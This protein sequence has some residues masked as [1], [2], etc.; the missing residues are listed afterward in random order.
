MRIQDLENVTFVFKDFKHFPGKQPEQ[1]KTLGGCP[2]EGVTVLRELGG[3][4]E[5]GDPE[6]LFC[7]FQGLIVGRQVGLG[8]WQL[9]VARAVSKAG[10]LLALGGGNTYSVRRRMQEREGCKSLGA[11]LLFRAFH[12]KP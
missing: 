8:E 1:R 3:A 10:V 12:V 6:R 7:A 11:R 5:A 9:Q 4:E 2:G